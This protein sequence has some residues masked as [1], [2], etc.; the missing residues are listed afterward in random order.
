VFTG[1][2]EQA[3][4]VLAAD[5]GP[6]SRRVTLDLAPLRGSRAPAGP[7]V[8]LGASVAVQGACLT[9]A[10]LEGDSAGF[11]VIT[12]TLERTTLGG[13]TAGVRVNVERA[14][15]FGD[16]VDGHLV[17]GHVERTGEVLAAESQPGQVWLTVRCG[18]DFAARTLPKGSVTIDGVSLTVAELG[19]DQLSVALVPH[20]LQRTTLGELSPGDRVNLE[21]DLIGQWVLRAARGQGA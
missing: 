20:T 5:P 3:C 8:E 10:A 18:A 17:Q 1:I 7:L 11:D 2:I 15:R 13:L 19:A 6:G 14:L 21:A 4:R 9:V 12:E 16:R